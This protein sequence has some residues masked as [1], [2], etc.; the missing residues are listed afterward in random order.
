MVEKKNVVMFVYD[1]VLSW[2]SGCLLNLCFLVFYEWYDFIINYRY[3]KIYRLL[4]FI[5]VYMSF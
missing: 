2:W 3:I 1:G 5:I 4:L